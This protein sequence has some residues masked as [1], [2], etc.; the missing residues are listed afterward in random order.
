MNI[1]AIIKDWIENGLTHGELK[2]KHR[3]T[4]EEEFAI[5]WCVDLGKIDPHPGR[6]RKLRSG[7]KTQEIIDI[8]RG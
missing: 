8:V 3:L 7:M 1:Q 2:S 5:T 4:S 6:L